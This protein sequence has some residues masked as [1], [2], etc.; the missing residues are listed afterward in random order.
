MFLTLLENLIDGWL[1]QTRTVSV[2]ILF[3][4]S[5]FL[6]F[7][8][9]HFFTF[10]FFLLR[11]FFWGGGALVFF[12]FSLS[13]VSFSFVMFVVF[14]YFPLVYHFL[15]QNS[16]ALLI[17]NFPALFRS[18]VCFSFFITVCISFVFFFCSSSCLV[19]EI[20][21]LLR[22]CF[23]HFCAPLLWPAPATVFT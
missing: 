9:L 6:V 14:L 4:G 2:F 11:L 16:S 10:S 17:F 5:V 21:I 12:V 7:Q 20:V 3:W 22:F 8:P 1:T 23:F 19:H 13:L 18:V 15:F